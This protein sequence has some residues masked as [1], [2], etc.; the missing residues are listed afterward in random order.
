MTKRSLALVAAALAWIG[1]F[2]A[3]AGEVF[4]FTS[5]R[6]NGEDGLHLALSTNGYEWAAVQGDRS[7]L[8]PEVGGKLMRD[9][10]LARGPDGRFHMVWTTGWTAE[11]GKVFGYASSR[12]LLSWSPQRAIE[13]M[14]HEPKTRNIWAPELFY[15]EA[16]GRW[17]IFWSSTIPGKY[18]ETDA[19]GDDGYNH[20]IY[21]V[22]T[23]DFE[24]FSGSRLFYD[25]GFNCIDATLLAGKGRFYMFFKDER[26]NPLKKVLRYAVADRAEGPYGA[27]SEPFTRDWVEGPSA[28]QI[29]DQWLV[30]F[31]HY[32]RP[33]YY[34]A[35][36]SKDLVNWE[37]CTK[38]MKFPSAPRH[39]TVLR[40][41]EDIAAKL[42]REPAGKEEG[43][44]G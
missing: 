9:P 24:T 42:M 40:I 19:T 14:Q 36:R 20:R 28:I 1:A 38:E 7:F 3:G 17:L 15:D 35:V 2:T 26:K 6:G 39:G 43:A 30:Y 44:G 18:P 16:N 8:R 31:D 4:L 25:P 27:P 22:T 5:F 10:C 29:G 12:D 23:K 41:P 37:D 32:A 11:S 33:Q 21:Y 34:G 13:V